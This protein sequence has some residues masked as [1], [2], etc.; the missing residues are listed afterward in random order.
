LNTTNKVVNNGIINNRIDSNINH[1][2]NITTKIVSNS[3]SNQSTKGNQSEI[4]DKM[5]EEELY[6]ST[7]KTKID[8]ISL[9]SDGEEDVYP[10]HDSYDDINYGGYDDDFEVNNDELKDESSFV[11]MDDPQLAPYTYL[12]QVIEELEK[13]S[14][15][16]SSSKLF[17][18]SSPSK[19]V[20]VKAAVTN[21]VRPFQFQKGKFSLDVEIDDGYSSKMLV[22][23]SDPVIQSILGMTCEEFKKNLS[24]PTTKAHNMSKLKDMEKEMARMEGIFSMELTPGSKPIVNDISNPTLSEIEKFC[25]FL[26]AEESNKKREGAVKEEREPKKMKVEEDEFDWE[27]T[28]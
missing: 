7:E 18:P 24:D 12:S 13:R 27:S 10:Y 21:L 6:P 15:N 14:T 8:P 28:S 2:T 1:N 23:L 11:D 4:I 9:V 20:K 16:S 17:D 3:S 25:N 5:E 22:T 26:E 19:F